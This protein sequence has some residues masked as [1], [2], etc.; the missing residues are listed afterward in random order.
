MKKI[1]EITIGAITDAILIMPI[2]SGLIILILIP[3]LDSESPLP[4]AMFIAFLGLLIISLAIIKCLEKE[5]KT[6]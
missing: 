5:N 6:H 3:F 2:I 4:M 1:K